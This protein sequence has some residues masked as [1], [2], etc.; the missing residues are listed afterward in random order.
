[1]AGADPGSALK[2]FDLKT[3]EGKVSAALPSE[4]SLCND[5]AIG[6][7]GSAFVTNTLSPE[8][9]RLPPGGK[10]LEIWFTNASLQP[11]AGASGLDGLAFGGD[12][13]LYVDRYTPG[14]LYRIDV[15]NGKAGKLTK[16][17]P[18]RALVLTDAIR[19]LGHN[20]FLLIEGGGRL[21]RMTIAGD[22]ATIETIKDGYAVPTG[23][24][25]VGGNA[26]VSEGQLSYL[27]DP[28]KRDQKPHLPFHLFA[29]PIPQ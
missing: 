4:K 20:N 2:G 24:T 27:F 7:D 8:I 22:N 9:L 21:D 29:V 26:W 28:S 15:N 6:P 19:P 16:L 10:Q 12:G 5:I 18:S 23:V 1:M 11:P 17:Q 3:G 13:N 25:Q 14:D